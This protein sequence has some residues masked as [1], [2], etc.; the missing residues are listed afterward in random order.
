MVLTSG[1]DRIFK[2]SFPNSAD[3]TY[4]LE[5]PTQVDSASTI[6]EIQ[7]ELIDG[8]DDNPYN[9][10]ENNKI[11]VATVYR[12]RNLE[13]SSTTTRVFEGTNE[14]IFTLT[15]DLAPEDP[16]LTVYYSITEDGTN[17]IT[18]TLK[19]AEPNSIDLPFS[20]TGD[21]G[22]I[23]A[24]LRVPLLDDDPTITDPSA[25]PGTITVTLNNPIG[26]VAKYEVGS[27]N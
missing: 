7:V 8:R 19:S 5:I 1:N 20:R 27:S 4:T 25:D 17:F 14:L 18:S 22:P 21:T 2:V 6:G 13:I 26:D 15:T 23:T 16:T 24:T 11:A 10:D 12:V 9:I 3:L